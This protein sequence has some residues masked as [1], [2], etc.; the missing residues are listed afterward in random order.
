[1]Q[2]QPKVDLPVGQYLQDKYGAIV[3]PFIVDKGTA[4]RYDRDI[5]VGN[6]VDWFVDGDGN[7]GGAFKSSLAE[8]TWAITTDSARNDGRTEAPNIH[9]YILSMAVS[10]E[11]ESGASKSFNI[12]PHVAGF[13]SQTKGKD[14]FL[15]VSSPF[16]ESLRRVVGRRFFSFDFK[17]FWR[18]RVQPVRF[19][20]ENCWLHECD[21]SEPLT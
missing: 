12:K 18:G 21:L 8:G 16:F 15:Q 3:G 4:I 19:D 20:A 2:I 6:I 11:L 7:S 13:M 5:S 1:M 10:R 9:A 14:S 17:N